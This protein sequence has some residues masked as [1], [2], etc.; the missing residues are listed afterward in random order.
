VAADPNAQNWRNNVLY[1]IFAASASIAI[2]VACADPLH[3]ASLDLWKW[4][5]EGAVEEFPPGRRHGQ[6]P[7]PGQAMMSILETLPLDC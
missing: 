2:P 5:S 7:L 1:Y 3:A 6:I 4:A